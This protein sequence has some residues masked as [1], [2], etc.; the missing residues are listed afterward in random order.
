VWSSFARRGQ[1]SG[2]REYHSPWNS[3]A[4]LDSLDRAIADLI[5]SG[6]EPTPFFA[7]HKIG[8][9]DLWPRFC[10]P[11]ESLIGQHG[12]GLKDWIT[13]LQADV[14]NLAEVHGLANA[15]E[16]LPRQ[17]ELRETMCF[18]HYR[19]PIVSRRK[20]RAIACMVTSS[21]LAFV[22]WIAVPDFIRQ[23]TIETIFSD[24]VQK[25]ILC[26]LGD[27]G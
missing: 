12:R 10:G 5:E 9:S 20:R 6:Q 14:A 1:S 13:I 2:P 27:A 21:S 4:H 24:C 25:R 7:E 22:S 26:I 8:Q 18:S 23:Q 3:R 17:R 16:R 15:N 19:S 11:V